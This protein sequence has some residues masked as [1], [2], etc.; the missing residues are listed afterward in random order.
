MQVKEIT[1]I[2]EAFAPLALQAGYDNAG[3]VCGSYAGEVQ[4]VLLCTDVTEAVVDE[5]IRERC[6]LVISHHPLI[7][8]GIKNLRPENA[9]NRCLVKAIQN[10]LHIYA[11]HTNMDS[12]AG[13]VSGRM[14]DKLGLIRQRVLQ[15]EGALYSLSFYTPAAEAERVRNAVLEAGG[16]H[17]GN[18]SRCS[19]NAEGTGTFLP[20]ENSRPYCGEL[21]KLHAEKEVKTEITVPEYRL[22][23]SI[24]AIR[25]NHPY[26]E[27]VWNV[28]KLH[29]PNPVT[30]LGII[31]ALPEAEDPLFFLKRV[32]DIFGCG[33]I[34]HTACGASRVQT[35]ALCGGAGA[36]LIHRAIR[37]KADVFLS[38]DFKYHEFFQ[39]ENRI[40]L[41][42]IGHYESERYTKEIFYEL[43]TKKMPKFAVQFSKVNTNPTNYL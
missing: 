16:G 2:V 13:G 36:S 26:E 8:Q 25:E 10:D 12:V 30:G 18:Y 11:A 21:H 27:P 39:A 32:R 42:D 34:R 7:F 24:R 43:I 4:G 17:I 35:V 38:G 20:L 37:E 9:V 15:P 40:I 1:D 31:G 14:A 29:T 41:A 5:A 23:D 28:V 19:F 6:N 22:N 3:L 33:V